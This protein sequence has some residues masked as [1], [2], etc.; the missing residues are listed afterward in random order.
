MPEQD[1]I[2]L[3]RAI[4]TLPGGGALP[5]VMLTSV[6]PGPT[7]RP[8]GSTPGPDLFAAVLT[9]PA[10]PVHVARAL[11][12]VFG[13]G[14]GGVLAASDSGIERDLAERIPL[15]ILLAE[16][17]RVNQ[18]VALKM[19]ERMGYRADV[20]AN[21]VE[22]VAALERQRYDVILMDMQM[23]EMDGIEATRQIRARWPR[24]GRPW[25][26]AMT[27]N[28][29]LEDR[30]ECMV[31]GMDDFL[32]KPVAA[33]ALGAALARCAPLRPVSAK[34]SPAIEPE[35]QGVRAAAG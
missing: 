7:G 22:A 33:K 5:L 9:K 20:A 26:V 25:I 10:R 11:A 35:S 29:M 27:A 1:G 16:D 4:R 6:G 28:A 24:E 8:D 23:P 12:R 32:S 2:D 13:V 18:K 17:N 19:L 15:R 3:A 30:N 31:A 14:D 21:G 34:V